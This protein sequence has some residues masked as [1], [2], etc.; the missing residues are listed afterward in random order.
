MSVSRRRFLRGGLAGLAGV[1]ADVRVGFPR[2][3]VYVCPP[4]GCAMDGR[5]FESPGTCPACGMTLVRRT[6]RPGDVPFEPTAIAPGAGVF[7]VAGGPGREAKRIAVH[8]YR[9][10]GFTPSSPILLV[11]PG[12]GRNADSYR[13]G[14]IESAERA[15]VLVAALSYPEA[16]YDFAAYHMGGVIRNLRIPDTPGRDPSVI[17][18]RDEDISFEIN[19]RRSERIFPDFDR[20]FALLVSLTGSTRTRY[21]VYG[22]SAGGQ[23]LH[24]L[25]LF[26][27]QSRAER[28]V[29]ANAGFYTLPD[30]ETP[31]PF[32]LAGT[33]VDRASLAQSFRCRLTLLL[34]ELDNDPEKGGIHLHTPLADRQGLH[35]L[36]RGHYFFRAGREAANEL[37]VPF[38]WRLEV[39]PGVGHDHRGM[40]AAAARYLYGA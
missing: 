36:A 28:I 11:L 15:G 1:W 14:W 19:D 6:T 10:A 23:I 12:D 18:L 9:P 35:R 5:E 25:A 21:D 24:R 7:L 38:E 8:Y 30:F 2:A 13:D 20:I 32:G 39:V 16:D 40:S 4:C 33:D 26:H 34:G 17:R 37:G 22:H 29:A 31:L 27:P 3:P